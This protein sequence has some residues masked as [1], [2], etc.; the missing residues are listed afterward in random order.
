MQ[1]LLT[2][3][4]TPALISL[5]DQPVRDIAQQDACTAAIHISCSLAVSLYVSQVNNIAELP[6]LRL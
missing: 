6:V 1:V 4:L 5:H 2:Q 3:Q